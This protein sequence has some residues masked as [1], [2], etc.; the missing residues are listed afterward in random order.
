[1]HKIIKALCLMGLATIVVDVSGYQPTNAQATDGGMNFSVTAVQPDNQIDKA[2]TYFDLRMSPGQKQELHVRMTNS[3]DHEITV[4]VQLNSATTNDNGVIDYS[5][6]LEKATAAA[7]ENN[8]N[9][10]NAAIDVKKIGYDSTLNYLISDIATGEKEVKLPAK[11]DT[12]YKINLKMPKESFDGQILGGIRFN[13]KI[14]E[15]QSA[16][17]G[18]GMQIQNRY[19]YVLG[20]SLK[21]TNEKVT[22]DMK[23]VKNK[24]KP[25]SVSGYNA[26]VIN[27]QNS[28]MVMLRDLAIDAK[29]YKKNSK[30]VLHEATDSGL[31]MAPNSNFNYAV[32]WGNKPLEAGTYLVKVN[33]ENRATTDETKE[34]NRKW[35]F[36]EEFT[37]TKADA[38]QVNEQATELEK[39]PIQW[40]VF[41]LVVMLLIGVLAVGG[42]FVKLYFDKK[43]EEERLKKAKLVKARK[44]KKQLSKQIAEK[45]KETTEE[46]VKK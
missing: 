5:W 9:K 24:I 35:N 29:I 14:T 4:E 33:A 28:K 18:S 39:A 17:D 11:S 26:V 23:I 30:K 32:D 40:W 7:K 16:D 31:K 12:I 46:Q 2:Q 13:E 36:E 20:L 21:E 15:K 6:N 19:A 37:I 22:P 8:K 41:V 42:Y 10:S 43:K 25:A 45:N 44:K 27:L 34:M 3:T 1:M 38:K